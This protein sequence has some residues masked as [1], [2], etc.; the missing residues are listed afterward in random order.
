MIYIVA[1]F[2]YIACYLVMLAV[3]EE[4]NKKRAAI[5]CVSGILLFIGA[6]GLGLLSYFDL[7]L[8]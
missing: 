8:Y 2:M 3:L 6:I 4:K 1:A 5:E 7:L